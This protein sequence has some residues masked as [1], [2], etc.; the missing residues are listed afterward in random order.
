MGDTIID[1]AKNSRSL[2]AGKLG[3]DSSLG[4]IFFELFWK[5]TLSATAKVYGF[6]QDYIG[7][8]RSS[9]YLRIVTAAILKKGLI[10]HSFI[11]PSYFRILSGKGYVQAFIFRHSPCNRRISS[12]LS[13]VEPMAVIKS[14]CMSCQHVFDIVASR[15]LIW[16]LLKLSV[17]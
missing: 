7:L 13:Q 10:Y 1:R 17:G 9:C 5:E 14:M 6:S 4:R 3:Y 12:P 16:M 15:L 11:S 8:I 2:V